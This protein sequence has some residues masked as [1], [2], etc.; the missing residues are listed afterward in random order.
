[1]TCTLTHCLQ[2][3]SGNTNVLNLCQAQFEW[4]EDVRLEQILSFQILYYCANP[5]KI[6]TFQYLQGLA[7]QN[8]NGHVDP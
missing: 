3:C 4:K 6:G 7:L 1:M 5:Q 2:T 8:R